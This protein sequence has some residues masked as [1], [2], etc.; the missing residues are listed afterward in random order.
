MKMA[1]QGEEL[2][3]SQLSFIE[4]R[5]ELRQQESSE[6]PTSSAAVRSR[7]TQFRIGIAEPGQLELKGLSMRGKE[8]GEETDREEEGEMQEHGDARTTGMHVQAQ[9]PMQT[10]RIGK[11]GREMEEDIHVEDN[12]GQTV[13]LTG[14][15]VGS[16]TYRI[17]IPDNSPTPC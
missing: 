3:D 12:D 9:A 10:Q 16:E 15:A 14:V 6:T 4:E 17:A 2:D 5:F 13:P 7:R 8:T 1:M 11:G